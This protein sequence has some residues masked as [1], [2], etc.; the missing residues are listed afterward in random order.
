MPDRCQQIELRVDIVDLGH[1]EIERVGDTRVVKRGEDL[2]NHAFE[3][4][5]A[6][7]LYWSQMVAELDADR[8]G[9]R[10]D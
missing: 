9:F 4:L 5:R 3:K 2:A 7:L 6:Q 10:I 1:V 8:A